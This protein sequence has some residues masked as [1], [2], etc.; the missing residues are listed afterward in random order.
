MIEKIV[1]LHFGTQNSIEYLFG[2]SCN[3]IQFCNFT[4]K[5]YEITTD[6]IKLHDSIHSFVKT[7]LMLFR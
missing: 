5:G 6:I 2:N 4:E 1:Y 7:D 3:P